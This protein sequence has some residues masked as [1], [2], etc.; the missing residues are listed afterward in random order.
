MKKHL[1]I[2]DFKIIEKN[3]LD[4][5]IKP[6]DKTIKEI[7]FYE[8]EDNAEGNYLLSTDKLLAYY[9]GITQ[10]PTKIKIGQS[11]IKK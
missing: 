9:Y 7:T 3:I 6:K 10:Y 2:G 8:T 5:Q 4:Y 11:N 1:N